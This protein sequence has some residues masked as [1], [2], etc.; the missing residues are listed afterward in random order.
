MKVFYLHVIVR[1]QT[2][3]P[4]VFLNPV[5][6]I[7]TPKQRMKASQIRSSGV[8]SR[9]ADHI[10]ILHTN[11]LNFY[12]NKHELRDRASKWRHV[13]LNNT[14]LSVAGLWCWPYELTIYVLLFLL[15]LPSPAH[16]SS[17]FYHLCASSLSGSSCQP[18]Q[19]VHPISLLYHQLN[20]SSCHSP[21]TNMHLSMQSYPQDSDWI[22]P[23]PIIP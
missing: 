12:N 15:P 8:R 5:S 11:A 17:H 1:K 13:D 2:L 3:C 4:I 19:L 21:T 18:H 23:P 10:E 9:E 22:F 16:N 6:T 20:L 7:L 14:K